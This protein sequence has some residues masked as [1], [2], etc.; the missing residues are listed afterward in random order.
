MVRLPL[1]GL[2]GSAPERKRTGNGIRAVSEWKR[3]GNGIEA[4][5]DWTKQS[6]IVLGRYRSWR[7]GSKRQLGQYRSG[8]GLEMEFERYRGGQWSEIEWN[9]KKSSS[10]EWT[11]V[12]SERYF[13]LILRGKSEC[14]YI[15]NTFV[16]SLSAVNS[17]DIWSIILICFGLNGT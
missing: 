15:W 8:N 7:N 12:K 17:R 4:E 14:Q 16:F 5:S 2:L 10:W 6:E 13:N 11:G 1:Q 3:I 9:W